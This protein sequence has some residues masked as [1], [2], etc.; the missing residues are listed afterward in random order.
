MLTAA[1]IKELYRDLFTITS[2]TI[3]ER[4]KPVLILPEY[5]GTGAV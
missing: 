1:E 2:V 3:A 4:G 5:F